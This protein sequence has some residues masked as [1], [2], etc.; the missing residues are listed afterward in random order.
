MRVL[1]SNVPAP[2]GTDAASISTII[3]S[4]QFKM[5][6]LAK[7]ITA[8]KS[9]P[10]GAGTLLDNTLIYASSEIGDS[11]AHGWGNMPI[12]LAGRGGGKIATGRTLNFSGKNIGDLFATL[13]TVAGVPTPKFGFG[14]GTLGGL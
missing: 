10:E 8:L 5:A 14:G 1:S 3:R 12:V 7:L 9:V 4:T 11:A 13:L 2:S 6:Q